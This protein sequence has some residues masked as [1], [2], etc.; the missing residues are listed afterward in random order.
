[1]KYVYD[2]FGPGWHAGR[3]RSRRAAMRV[4]RER[5]GA[6]VL[7]LT[8]CYVSRVCT[9]CAVVGELTVS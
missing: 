5:T 6:R 8:Y 4:A 2:V 3:Y 7:Q 1:M 9:G